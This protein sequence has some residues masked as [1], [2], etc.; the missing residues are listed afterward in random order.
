MQISG[1]TGPVLLKPEPVLCE[2]LDIEDSLLQLNC[3][4]TATLTVLNRSNS[5]YVFKKGERIGSV[6]E[7]CVIDSCSEE[8]KNL[9]D[10]F[11]ES[12][13]ETSKELA[14]RHDKCQ[15]HEDSAEGLQWRKQHM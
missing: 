2:N 4:N 5:T 10:N 11:P 8:D 15:D 14:V 13:P 7:V 12:C 3:D 9:L 1:E 6:C